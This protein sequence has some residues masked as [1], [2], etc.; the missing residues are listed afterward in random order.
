MDESVIAV[1]PTLSFRKLVRE[2]KE[3]MS[4][5]R[6]QPLTDTFSSVGMLEMSLMPSLVI[7]VYEALRVLNCVRAANGLRSVIPLHPS[8][9]RSRNVVMSF[10]AGREAS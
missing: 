4:S 5:I 1:S 2:R 6:V 3:L 10:R 8:K 9:D 7:I